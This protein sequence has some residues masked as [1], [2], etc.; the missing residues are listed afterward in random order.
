MYCMFLQI[1]KIYLLNRYLIFFVLKQNSKVGKLKNRKTLNYNIAFKTQENQRF[2][3]ND[4]S[5]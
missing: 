3:G 4:I 5:F 1:T 2:S